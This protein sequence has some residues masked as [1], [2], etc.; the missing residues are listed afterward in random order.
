MS[1]QAAGDANACPVGW[2]A[3]R[4]RLRI[5]SAHQH[6]AG[7]SMR[8][9]SSEGTMEVTSLHRRPGC[10]LSIRCTGTGWRLACMCRY[11]SRRVLG[12]RHH[13]R[14][15]RLRDVLVI[16]RRRPWLIL[17]CMARDTARDLGAHEG[18]EKRTGMLEAEIASDR[19]SRSRKAE[20]QNTYY[21]SRNT[22]TAAAAS[23]GHREQ[24]D[25]HQRKG[26]GRKKHL[27]QW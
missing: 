23:G 20:D 25:G 1:R 24:G 18:S 16:H 22:Y 17:A 21:D 6:H 27:L 5:P 3:L 11:S 12:R 2:C 15:P 26:D 14:L 10:S 4:H 13:H 8:A 9:Y 19:L 7:A